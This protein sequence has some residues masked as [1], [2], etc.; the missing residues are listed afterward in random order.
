MKKQLLF[1]TILLFVSNTPMGAQTDLLLPKLSFELDFRFRVEQDWNSRRP[2]GTFRDDRT[3]FRYRLRT[4]ATFKNDWYALGFRIR[5]G[6]QNKQQDP[7]LTLGKG[8]SEFGTLP[9]GFEK[10]FFKADYKNFQFWLGKNSFSFTKN[11]E[12]FW[13]DNV[14]P[15]GIF[16]QHRIKLA[17]HS[18]DYITLKG[19]HYILTSNDRSPLKDAYF[20]GIQSLIQFKNKRFKLFPAVYL[21]RNIPNIPDGNHSF[22]LD[23]SIIHIGSKLIVF[24]TENIFIDVD[25]YLNLEDYGSNN[26]ISDQIADEK[27]GFS[28]GI[29]YG[30]LEN[31]KDW[32]FKVTYT[33]M[34]KFAALDYMAQNDWARWDYSSFNSPDGRLTNLQ[35]I[36]IVAAYNISKKANITAKYYLVEQLIPEG[37]FNETGQRIRFDL[38]VKM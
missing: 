36:E 14:F 29:Q 30:T 16:V 31:A 12:L 4:G 6:D 3:R 28:M 27:N 5:T 2:D 25:F 19:S 18:I 33:A 35:G 15:E 1:V 32:K 26:N 22:T 10:L 9:L 37:D 21:L 13:S 34:Q 8:F 7:Q 38:N 23:Y 11:N 20:Q 17:N 24:K